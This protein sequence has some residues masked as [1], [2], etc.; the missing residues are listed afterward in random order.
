MSLDCLWGQ[1]SKRTQQQIDSLRQ[2]M[3][4]QA[5]SAHITAESQLQKQ[6]KAHEEAV[7]LASLDIILASM[8]L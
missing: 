8:L 5:H 2:K 7:R 4:K 6:Q 3:A 1:A